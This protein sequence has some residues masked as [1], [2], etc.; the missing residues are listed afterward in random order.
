MQ[1]TTRTTANYP[2]YQK[3]T[4]KHQVAFSG[5]IGTKIVDKCWENHDKAYNAL[6]RQYNK[7]WDRHA[8]VCDE[9]V[10]KNIATTIE[11]KCP[12]LYKF[13]NTKIGKEICYIAYL[14]VGA[15]AG[16]FMSKYWY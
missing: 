13:A 4:N 16:Y 15:A 11:K 5:N 9:I 6:G 10:V 8:L 14:S 3:N 12:A 7:A 1:L 2:T